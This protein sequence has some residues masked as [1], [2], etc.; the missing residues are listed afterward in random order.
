MTR[1]GEG[2]PQF[3][4]WIAFKDQHPAHDQYVW[5]TDA[6]GLRHD[7]RRGR[8][9]ERTQEIWDDNGNDWNGWTHW[10]PFDEPKWTGDLWKE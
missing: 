1:T 3:P 6:R 5:V 4:D 7:V 10:I 9:S 2:R 8:W